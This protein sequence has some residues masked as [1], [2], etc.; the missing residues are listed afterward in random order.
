MSADACATDA[1]RRA[2]AIS[3]INAV[4]N[5]TG[6]VATDNSRGVTQTAADGRHMNVLV[7]IKVRNVAAST[8]GVATTGVDG[9][10]GIV[11]IR[12]TRPCSCASGTVEFRASMG[13]DP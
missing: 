13:L 4:S 2:A 5:Q 9:K 10:A 6:V 12:Y 11:D 3:A 1:L 8:F 7:E